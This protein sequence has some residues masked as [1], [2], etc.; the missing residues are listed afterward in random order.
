[1]IFVLY[2]RSEKAAVN[3]FSM[4]SQL[5]VQSVFKTYGDGETI[6]IDGFKRMLR[7]INME[8]IVTP[9]VN[10]E[11]KYELLLHRL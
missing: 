9:T 5:F 4:D 2:C 10:H 7:S 3:R 8:R 1:M 6:S 11:S